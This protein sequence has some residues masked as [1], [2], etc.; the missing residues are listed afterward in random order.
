MQPTSHNTAE[1]NTW[2]VPQASRAQVSHVLSP[3]K[4]H[5]C[6]AQA[7]HFLVCC[8]LLMAVS[9]DPG[10]GTLTGRTPSLPSPRTDWTTVRMIRSGP[11]DAEAV[12]CDLATATRRVL[13]PP[14]DGVLSLRG[15]RPLPATRGRTPPVGRTTRQSAHEPEMFG[16]EVVL[17]L[18]S[19]ERSRVPGALA[20]L[21]PLCRGHQH[22]LFRQRLQD[23]VP[24]AGVPQVV[25]VAAAGC[26][27]NAPRRLRPAQRSADVF[28]RPRP[29]TLTHGTPLRA[30]VS[31]GPNRCAH[32]RAS[33]TPDGRRR[34][35]GGVL[36]R[37]T[38]HKLGDVTMVLSKQRRNDGPQG[39][40]MLVTPLPEA[41]A[42][43]SLSLYAWRW[44]G[45]A[46][47]KSA[48]EWSPSGAEASNQGGRTRAPLGSIVGAGLSPA[49]PLVWR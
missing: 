37:A 30:L 5:C 23:C 33:P 39:V 3:L 8:W 31:H 6:C 18:A 12:G 42:G 25:V 34:D 19:G 44:G 26:A 13:P 40:N 7:Q 47:E 48:E 10:T 28:A 16:G 43:A 46:D 15:D 24:P 32:R 27:A 14:A 11:G 45:R 2:G 21:D 1:R 49:G 9:R 20:R 38:R 41:S 35:D 22:R 29:R 4:R 36:R 17:R